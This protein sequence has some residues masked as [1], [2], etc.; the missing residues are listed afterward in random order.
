MQIHYYN[1]RYNFSYRPFCNTGAEA[2]PVSVLLCPKPLPYQPAHKQQKLITET[3]CNIKI[4]VIHKFSV[5]CHFFTLPHFRS[6]WFRLAFISMQSALRYISLADKK[7][8]QMTAVSSVKNRIDFRAVVAKGE[9]ICFAQRGII[10]QWCRLK[11]TGLHQRQ[12]GHEAWR[13]MVSSKPT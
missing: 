11:E 2:L 8:R 4:N 12:G 7:W 13:E 10:S 3:H 1:F 5:V 6:H 9:C